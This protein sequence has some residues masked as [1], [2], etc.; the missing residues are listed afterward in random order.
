MPPARR[1]RPISVLALVGAL[2]A[3]CGGG[4]TADR[5]APP[6]TPV[7]LAAAPEPARASTPATTPAGTVVALGGGRPE[8]L[9]ADP[10][11]GLVAVALRDPDRLALFDPATATVLRTVPVPGSARHLDL[12]PGGGVLVPGEDTDL[13]STVGLPAGEVLSSVATGRQPHDVAVV[14]G[15]D[16]YVADEFGGSV[17]LVR[18]G[19]VVG[20][21][22]GLLQ[23][24]GAQGAGNA[25]VVV[26]V[27]ARLAHVYRDGREVGVLPAGAGPTHVL[28]VGPT[29]VYVAD[30][31]GDA[32]L[33]YDLGGTPRQ[34]GSTAL[35]G[36][37]YGMAIDSARGLVYVTATARNLLVAYRLTADGLEPVR[38]WPTVRDAYD[39][40][41]VPATGRVVVAG[42]SG[43]ELQVI[44]P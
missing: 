2:L 30:T 29:T 11:S 10:A 20:T 23:P 3:G 6:A 28:A 8:G 41:V 36:R 24:G 26:D 17:S 9:V 31:S 4:A 13:L 32:L 43:S 39:V 34:T 33:R 25:A 14:T 7:P 38:T 16:T 40:V 35:A 37:P 27:R 21:F 5:P 12:A 42:E 15:G 22:R 18:G 1:T 44:D 19:V